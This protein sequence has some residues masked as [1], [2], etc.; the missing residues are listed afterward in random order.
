MSVMDLVKKSDDDDDGV[1]RT[2]VLEFSYDTR[3]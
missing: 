2:F 3:V 1:I